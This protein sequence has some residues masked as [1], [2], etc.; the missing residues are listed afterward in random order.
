MFNQDTVVSIK[1]SVK[2]GLVTFCTENVWLHFKAV[3]DS[4]TNQSIRLTQRKD[5]EVDIA[6]E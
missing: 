5:C 1:I 2:W 4:V 6:Q 3:I